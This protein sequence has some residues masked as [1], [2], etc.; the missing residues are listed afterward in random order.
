[1]NAPLSWSDWPA[2]R[3]PAV[4]V[5]AGLVIVVFVGAAASFDTAL[6][7][8]SAVI[9]LGSTAEAMLPTRFEVDEDGVSATNPLRAFNKD[10]A[11]LG[12]WR[13][14]EGGVWIDGRG[15]ARILRRRG[16]LLR[17]APAG[18]EDVIRDHLGAPA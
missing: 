10:W 13:A 14:V 18:V 16:V 17:G 1:M 6:G 7:I 3:R 11:R 12:A 15:R 9:L 8:L 2:R 4:S 5:L